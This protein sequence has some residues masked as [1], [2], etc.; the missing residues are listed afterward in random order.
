MVV[1]GETVEL[2]G[3]SRCGGGMFVTW[4]LQRLPPA[5]TIG[6][7]KLNTTHYRGFSKHVKNV[8]K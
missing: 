6:F 7:K 1:A 8:G 4:V 2:L 5:I 3:V